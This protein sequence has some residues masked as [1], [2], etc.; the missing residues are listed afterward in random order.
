[1]LTRL[2]QLSDLPAKIA[3]VRDTLSLLASCIDDS[4]LELS[5][6]T[7]KILTLARWMAAIERLLSG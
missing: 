6:T 2:G 1:M 7:T 5:S 4:A 3:S